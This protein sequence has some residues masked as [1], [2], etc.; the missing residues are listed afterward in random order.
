MCGIIHVKRFDKIPCAKM[1][2]KR[3][4]KQKARGQEGFGYLTIDKMINIERS[5]KE[6]PIVESLLQ[7]KS[8]E[9]LFHH[10]YP[11]ST[12]NVEEAT[13]P[14]L[15]SNKKL[16]HDYYLA[17]NGIITND[18]SLRDRHIKE[19]Y[20]YTTEIQTQIITK[21]KTYLEPLTWNDSE[22]L[23]VEVA[24][25]LDGKSDKIDT[26]GSVAFVCYQVSKKTRKP[27]GLY[28][29][30]N[31]GNPLKMMLNSQFFSLTSEGEGQNIAPDTLYHL[32]IKTNDITVV[33]LKIGNYYE[34]KEKVGG[35]YSSYSGIGYGAGYEK[36]S[37][38]GYDKYEDNDYL[39]LLQ[40]KYEIENQIRVAITTG[41]EALEIMLREEQYDIESELAEMDKL[42]STAHGK[43]F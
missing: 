41:D 34:Y 1:V 29:A 8:A 42:H 6:K 12:S 38:Q 35:Y 37:Y 20:T 30:R 18:T 33:P 26:S 10:R 28:F 21:G 2:H 9:I 15:V 11:T 31:E 36:D 13:H 19:G 7:E 5:Q 39:S 27:T 24:Q 25:Y 32:D 3:Y 40:D 22:S 17:H 14:I 23:A 43:D 4:E 16:S